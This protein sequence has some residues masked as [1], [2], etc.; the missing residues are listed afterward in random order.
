MNNFIYETYLED[1]GLCD[2]LI[3]FYKNS[4]EKIAGLSGNNSVQE[5]V[6]K[7]TDLTLTVKDE[8]AIKYILQLN[9]TIE[10][11]GNIY[12]YCFKNIVININEAINIQHYAPKEGFY[13][14]HSEKML[15]KKGEEIGP[16][17]TRHL[18]FMTYLNDVED[19]GG[20]EFLYQGVKTTAVKGKTL[21]FPA[22]WTHTH[23]G[24]ISSTQDKYIITGWL[25]LVGD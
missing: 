4:D 16:Q 3:S 15:I 25:S 23:R 22:Q 9:K 2:E 24:V 19:G 1:I 13:S 12:E 6:K 5:H 21:I 10:E 17:I 7:S 8:V 11:Y 20:T 14:W 18:V